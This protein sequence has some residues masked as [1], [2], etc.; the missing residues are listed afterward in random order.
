MPV[1]ALN[2]YPLSLAAPPPHAAC[3]TFE[4]ISNPN[5]SAVIAVSAAVSVQLS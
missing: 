4:R 2:Q 3:I 5:S 1:V